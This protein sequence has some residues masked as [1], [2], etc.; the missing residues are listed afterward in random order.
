MQHVLQAG[1]FSDV[2]SIGKKLVRFAK[3]TNREALLDERL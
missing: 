2:P 1:G 3:S